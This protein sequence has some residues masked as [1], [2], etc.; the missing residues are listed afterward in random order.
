MTMDHQVSLYDCHCDRFHEDDA[1]DFHRFLNDFIFLVKSQQASFI[2]S[3]KTKMASMNPNAQSFL[4][5]ADEIA[6]IIEIQN[7]DIISLKLLFFESQ[8]EVQRK[9]EEIEKLKATIEK[10]LAEKK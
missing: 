1:L 4:P 7:E 10:L 9:D 2:Y 6:K 8:I 5:R 3:A